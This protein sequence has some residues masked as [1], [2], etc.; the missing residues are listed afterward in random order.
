MVKIINNVARMLLAIGY[1]FIGYYNV[2]AMISL[3]AHAK[4][5]SAMLCAIMVDIAWATMLFFGG[6][7]IYSITFPK[8]RKRWN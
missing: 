1:L 2:T 4:D 7:L 5:I 6:I 8:K 3:L